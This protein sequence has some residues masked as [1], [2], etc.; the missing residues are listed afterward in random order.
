MN[1]VVPVSRGVNGCGCNRGLGQYSADSPLDTS[2]VTIAPPSFMGPCPGGAVMNPQTGDCVMPT[3]PSS[4]VAPANST[5][6]ALAVPTTS[7][8]LATMFS[9]V[10][11]STW[12]IVGGLVVAA[13]FMGGGRRR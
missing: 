6:M 11:G 5:A 9:T 3:S 13:M 12:V 1:M 2:G 10:P 4:Y 8:A 7:N